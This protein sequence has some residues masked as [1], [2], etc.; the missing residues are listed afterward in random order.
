MSQGQG[1]HCEYPFCNEQI[2][3]YDPYTNLNLC[4][5]HANVQ[6]SEFKEVQTSWTMMKNKKEMGPV[7]TGIYSN[8]D[9]DSD[10]NS[11]EEYHPSI[12]NSG[13]GD[14][15]SVVGS[16]EEEHNVQHDMEL[17]DF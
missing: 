4:A 14:D 11:D 3:I 9:N 13:S 10:N 7:C 2:F 6:P 5:D 8:D 1:E 12:H 15:V 17:T 16:D